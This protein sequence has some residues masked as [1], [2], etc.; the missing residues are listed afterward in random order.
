[1]LNLGKKASYKYIPGINEEVIAETKE[2][3]DSN[4]VSSQILYLI[5]Q[6]F[7]K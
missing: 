6:K 4:L 7:I 5:F 2:K 1:M 3:G